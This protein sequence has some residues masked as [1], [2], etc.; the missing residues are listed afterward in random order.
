MKKR[1]TT[2]EKK[3]YVYR[4]VNTHEYIIIIV[5]VVVEMCTTKQPSLIL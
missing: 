5:V 2:Q 4:A 3:M 1:K